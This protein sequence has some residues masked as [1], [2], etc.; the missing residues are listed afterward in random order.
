M[1]SIRILGIDYK[2]VFFDEKD[3]PQFTV[4]GQFN[5]QTSTIYIRK[6]MSADVTAETILHEIIEAT[7]WALGF[8]LPHDRLSALSGALHQVLKDNDLQAVVRG[9][10]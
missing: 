2:L 6:G 8:D 5:S 7:T 9:K 10:R 3:M 4:C 1:S